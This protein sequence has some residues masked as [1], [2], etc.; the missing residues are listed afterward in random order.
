MLDEL[1]EDAVERMASAVKHTQSE[2]ATLR[3]D[4]ASGAVLSRVMVDYY[5]ERV[6]LLELARTASHENLL[7]VIPH[8]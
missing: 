6:A 2:F 3:T 7:V 1:L 5:G 4:R 8:D